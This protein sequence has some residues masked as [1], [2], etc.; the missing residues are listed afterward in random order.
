MRVS[1][2][3]ELIPRLPELTP[4]M[5]LVLSSSRA[6]PERRWTGSGELGT[7]GNRLVDPGVV[8]RMGAGVAATE[9]DRIATLYTR[10]VRIIEALCEGEWDK[11]VDLM[12]AQGLEEEA[13]GRDREAEE[14]FLTARRIARDHGAARGVEAL[15]LAARAAR[16][17]GRLDD[18]ALRYEE[19]WRSSVQMAQEADAVVAA[20]GRGNV[21]V[22]RGAWE[23]ARS[24]YE[25]ALARIGE[26]G[27]PRRER[28]QALQNL[29]I[30]HRRSGDL[31]EARK[32]LTLAEAEGRRLED[33]DA[34][35]EIG[36]G[37]G[38]LLMAEGN[39]RG[40]ELHFVEALSVA[41][42]PRARAV[43]S[44]NLGEALLR[45][46]RTLEAG[47]RAREA[48]SEALRGGV[49]A[50]LPEV[51]RLLAQ[52]SRARGEGEAFVILEQ[53]LALITERALPPF[54]EALTREA[55]GELRV[56]GGDPSRGI[57]ELR[58]AAG[59]YRRLGMHDTARRLL[60]A[61]RDVE[62]GA[63]AEADDLSGP[64]GGEGG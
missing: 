50:K 51:Y 27:P 58:T 14:W 41:G 59:I 57:H 20:I 5:D 10:S 12:L 33:T 54:E 8:A 62:E 22:D 44:V 1:E 47:E 38:Q 36:N 28:W 32:A 37:W 9:A 60:E 15:R 6:D 30:V 53:A 39:Y 63:V 3:A 55:Y 49:V 61:A 34:A 29:A 17:L 46:G 13:S 26:H 40:A 48:E 52:V 25:R 45:Q 56:E 18:A 23:E 64:E 2:I 21:A 7:V 19:A 42:T 24:W 31:E 4:L 16:H 35:V 43:I 11:G